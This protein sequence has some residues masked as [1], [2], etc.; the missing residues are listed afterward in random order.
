[1][2]R[3]IVALLGTL[4]LAT[5]LSGCREQWRSELVSVNGAGTD[6]GN[7][8]SPGGVLSSDGTKVAFATLGSDFGPTDTNGNADVYVR[9]MAAGVTTLVSVNA[10]G[11]NSSNHVSSRPVFSPDATQVAF[12]SYASNLGPTDTNGVDDIYLRDLVTG[13]TTLVSVNASGTDAGWNGADTARFSP[14]GTKILFRGSGDYVAGDVAGTELYMHDL[15]AGVTTRVSVLA[16]GAILGSGGGLSDAAFSPDSTRVVFVSGSQYV[17]QD[18]N[19][20]TDVY[21]RDLVA[22]TTTLVSVNA[23]GTNGANGLSEHPVFSPDGAKIAFASQGTDFGFPDAG[24]GQE[25]LIRDLTTNT[26]SLVT[27]DASGAGTACGTYSAAFS[28]DGTKIAFNCLTAS[29]G[30][31]DTNDA[32]DTYVRDLVNGT[33]T[34]V[35][36]NAAGNDSGN[37]PSGGHWWDPTGTKILFAGRASD[38][39]PNDTHVGTDVYIRDLSTGT[40]SLVSANADGSDSGNLGSQPLACAAGK[41]LLSS[42]ASDHG[43]NDTN[44]ELDLYLA[45]VVPPS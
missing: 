42:G 16:P 30:P 40:T 35:S 31:T 18:T 26:T 5:L 29:L 28:P 17:P 12:S 38:L 23:A 36:V 20:R 2:R 39:G 37:A 21:L 11:T 1:M 27:A 24:S 32:Y 8:S 44:G 25:L 6:S 34:L 33:T 14:D 3:S 13:T 7:G 43:P 15:V 22:G 45:S 19:L 9:D 4:L 41:V 10:A